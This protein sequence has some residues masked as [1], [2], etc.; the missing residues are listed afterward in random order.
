MHIPFNLQ[1]YSNNQVSYLIF[2]RF[3][4]LLFA[5]VI[6]LMNIVHSRVG[7]M[8]NNLVAARVL[9]VNVEDSL[10]HFILLIVDKGQVS[11]FVDGSSIG[12]R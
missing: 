2:G 7:S 1:I 8:Q 6:V 12:T 11:F 9:N 5:N 10:W 3:L 4:C